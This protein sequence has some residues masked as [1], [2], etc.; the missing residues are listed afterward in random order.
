MR[1]QALT[2]AVVD[3]LR[4]RLEQR[5]VGVPTTA[6]ALAI[7]SGVCRFA[8]AR[9]FLSTNPVREVRKPKGRRTRFV[10]PASPVSVE[11]IRLALLQ[12][13]RVRDATLVSVLAYAGLRPGEALGLRWTDVG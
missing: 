10:T 6:K 12:R 1:I 11:A 9:G 7:L 13:E 5:G 3:D 2:P 4:A 8:V